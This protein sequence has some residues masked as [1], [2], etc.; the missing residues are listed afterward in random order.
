[1]FSFIVL[2]VHNSICIITVIL[3]ILGHGS[4]LHSKGSLNKKCFVINN[5]GGDILRFM[6]ISCFS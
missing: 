4:F 5:L 3:K 2:G 1:M 6:Q